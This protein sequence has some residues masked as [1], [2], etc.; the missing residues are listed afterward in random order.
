MNRILVLL[1]LLFLGIPAFAHMGYWAGL[2]ITESA[3]SWWYFALAL[4][5]KGVVVAFFLKSVSKKRLQLTIKFTAAFFIIGF[6]FVVTVL[7]VIISSLIGMLLVNYN[8]L[9]TVAYTLTAITGIFGIS[10]MENEI[11]RISKSKLSQKE[12]LYLV[13]CNTILISIVTIIS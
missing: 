10:L 11:V 3:Y 2:K 12:I 8:D 9:H 5:I 4:L 6:P 7:G 1:I 13:L